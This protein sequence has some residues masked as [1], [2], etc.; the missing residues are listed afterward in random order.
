MTDPSQ[1]RDTAR[2]GNLFD[3]L[4][5]RDFRLYWIG[6]FRSHL[7]DSLQQTAVS[8]LLYEITHSPLTLG[9]NGAFRAV[10]MILLGLFGGTLADRVDRRRVLLVTQTILM[11]LAL[12]LGVLD[13]KGH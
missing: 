2:R 6:D 4:R 12:L 8:W 9:L 3:V 10:P 1:S 7:G 13:Q 11:M 5:Y